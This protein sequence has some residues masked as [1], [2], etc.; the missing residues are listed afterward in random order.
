MGINIGGGLSNTST[1]ATLRSVLIVM[2]SIHGIGGTVGKHGAWPTM[3]TKQQYKALLVIRDHGPMTPREF[4]EKM[5]PE[6]LGWNRSH[7]VGRGSSR[8]A[9]MAATGGAYLGR[10]RKMGFTRYARNSIGE[11]P[12]YYN[13]HALT[14]E[15]RGAIKEYGAPPVDPSIGLK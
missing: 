11:W 3:I 9:A 10:L 8:G 13:L 14:P 15:G 4:A 2:L 6:S 5:W 1:S 12:K 7:K